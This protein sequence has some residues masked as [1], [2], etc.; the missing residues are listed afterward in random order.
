MLLT[1]VAVP[2]PGAGSTT[3]IPSGFKSTAG[4]STV[5]EGVEFLKMRRDSPA[6]DATVGHIAPNAPIRLRVVNSNDRIAHDDESLEVPSSQCRGLGCLLGINGDFHDSD[7]EPLG[8]VVTQGRLIRTPNQ[9][10]PHLYVFANGRVGMG[11]LPWTATV[12]TKEGTP[13]TLGFSGINTSAFPSNGL[14]LYTSDWGSRTRSSGSGTVELIVSPGTKLAPLG[15]TV[16]VNLSALDNADSTIPA[17]GAVLSG[18]GS[19]ATFLRDLW[20]RGVRQV[21]VR[22]DSAHH[23]VEALGGNPFIIGDGQNAYPD[24]GDSFVT[25]RQPRTFVG[26]SDA[27]DVFIVTVDGRRSASGGMSLPEAANFLRGLGA[28]HGMNFDGGGGTVFVKE[29]QVVSRPVDDDNSAGE[30]GAPN[31][32]AVVIAPPTPGAPLP[33][34]PRSGYWMVSSDGSVYRFGD[35]RQHGFFKMAPNS[36]VDLEPTPSGN[37]YWVI[38]NIGQVFAM[39]DAQH[40]GNVDRSKLVSGEQVTSVSATPSGA[41]YW[42]FTSKGRVLAFGN[43]VHRGDLAAIKLNGPVLDSVAT[44][45]GNGYYMVASDGGVFTFGDAAFYGSTGSIKLNKP[46]Q[47]LVP[48]PDGVGYWLVASDG[49]VF[50]FQSVFRGAMGSTKLNKPMSGMVAFGNGYLM[51]AEDGG[52]F[53]FSNKPFHGSLGSCPAASPVISLAPLD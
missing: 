28:T 17:G 33:P 16:T 41:G 23:P 12:K 25:S 49:G 50:T 2:M 3:K 53:N 46:V 32:L 44:P 38:N 47:S 22:A 37:G 1:A 31:S 4:C 15:Q 34:G 20:N 7:H 13:R 30:R 51:V 9:G 18:K 48:D 52:I 43:A 8:G 35:A 10:R 27:G 45:S 24:N 26:F 11:D 21:E 36:A 5:A 29:G 39:G 19:A 40:F 6:Q 42:A 14:N